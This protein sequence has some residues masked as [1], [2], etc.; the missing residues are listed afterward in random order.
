MHGADRVS[1][2][3]AVMYIFQDGALPANLIV[4]LGSQCLFHAI[5]NPPIHH[6]LR[7]MIVSANYCGPRDIQQVQSR[8]RECS[9]DPIVPVP[10]CN[11]D[12]ALPGNY[13]IL[14]RFTRYPVLPIFNGPHDPTSDS[15]RT[16]FTKPSQ[17]TRNLSFTPYISPRLLNILD[18]TPPLSRKY[19]KVIQLTLILP[20]FGANVST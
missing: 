8:P 20:N 3:L 19:R 10:V 9:G 6:M 18:P 4:R 2:W 5:V 12:A 14:D 13:R 7:A 15:T 11:L 16:N 1:T 17:S